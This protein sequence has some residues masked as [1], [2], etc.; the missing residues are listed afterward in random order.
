MNEM[1]TIAEKHRPLRGRRDATC[2]YMHIKIRFSK[3][4]KGKMNAKAI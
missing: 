4:K 1:V 3:C 2:K